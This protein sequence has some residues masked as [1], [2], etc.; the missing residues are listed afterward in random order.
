MEIVD[1]LWVAT[2]IAR[3]YV[4]RNLDAD[5][6]RL[7]QLADTQDGVVSRQQLLAMGWASSRVARAA[8]DW[9]TFAPGVYLTDGRDV[10]LP[11]RARAALL[12]RPDGCLSHLTAAQSQGWEVLDTRPSWA[13]MDASLMGIKGADAEA[14]VDE[15]RWPRADQV[16]LTCTG[17]V[18]RPLPGLLLHRDPTVQPALVGGFRVTE[19]ARTL[20]DVARSAYFL[21]AVCLLDAR[22]R[23]TPG[24]RSQVGAMLGICGGTRGI[25]AAQRA[26]RFADEKSESVLESLLRLLIILAGLPAPTVQLQVRL[27]QLSFRADLGYEEA[28][29]LIEAD[30]RDYHSEWRAVG[31]DLARQNALMNAGWRVLRFTWTQILFQPELV[32][33]AIRQALQAR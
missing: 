33:N 21:V 22:F 19:A 20:V 12:A 27:G 8:R 17:I 24:L 9:R 3:A 30:G 4:V 16:E 31:R 10:S 23:Q 26:L 25:V 7:Q 18:S 2:H 6:A 29:L 13:A 28:R 14:K 5:T 1:S 15:G 11:V 32:I